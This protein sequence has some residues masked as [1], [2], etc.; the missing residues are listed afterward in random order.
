M[1]HAE[2]NTGHDHRPLP[3]R[4]GLRRCAWVAL[5]LLLGCPRP[6]PVEPTGTD[7]PHA[8]AA[9]AG[10]ETALERAIRMIDAADLRGG[11]E[12]RD[13]DLARAAAAGLTEDE[14]LRTLAELLADCLAAS[15]PCEDY[16]VGGGMLGRPDRAVLEM[17]F[18]LLGESGS[19][20]ALPWLVRLDA[21]HVRRAGLALERILERRWEVERARHPPTPPTTD[22]VAGVRAT[23]GDFLA[24]RVRDGTLVAETP[25]AAELDDL[26]YFLAAV[27]DAGPE[28]GTARESGRGSFARPGEPDPAREELARALDEAKYAG[29]LAAV[30]RTGLAYLESLGYPGPIRTEEES[31]YAWGGASWSYAM[32]D[33]AQAAE[34]TGD[35]ELAEAL[36]RRARPG[37]GAC[38]TSVDYRWRQQI[39]GTIRAAELAGRANAVVAERLI[40]VDGAPAPWSTTSYGPQPLAE[41][42]FDLPRLY[43]GALVTANRDA[44]HAEL[45]AALRAA[46]AA[47]AGPALERLAA[48]GPEAWEPRVW[49]LEGLADTAGREA[50]P[51][52]FELLA[53]G[54]SAVRVRTLRALGAAAE[55][56]H[57]DPCRPI[58][59]GFGEGSSEWS[60]T[61]SPFGH[62]CETVI[63]L[64]E[65]DALAAR[66]HPLLED[67]EPDVRAAAAEALGRIGSPTSRER[68]QQVA[69]TDPGDPDAGERCRMVTDEHGTTHD[70]CTPYQP[71]REAALEA[72]ERLDRVESAWARQARDLAADPATP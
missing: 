56:P 47:L 18:T 9:P 65:T 14:L 71:V 43:R 40:A 24:V 6:A 7:D 55:R 31:S 15:A 44:D 72:L 4:A 54:R 57:G 35:A 3:G 36:Y 21:R 69:D 11:L 41:A 50:L 58:G 42:G 51:V 19:S 25:A 60:R 28:V 45:E 59:F 33:V 26:A 16:S 38:G 1:D 10:D 12:T 29:D 37:G 13:E 64:A 62:E 20:A 34:A 70:E 17:L 52:L 39:E 5:P 23:L 53:A 67:P 2:S 27:G 63:T 46:P 61:I 8:D 30:R 68:L 49:A 22:Q 48:R 66:L 32:R